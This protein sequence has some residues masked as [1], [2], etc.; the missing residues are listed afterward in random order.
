VSRAT[1]AHVADFRAGVA[2][3]PRRAVNTH[4]QAVLARDAAAQAAQHPTAR[5]ARRPRIPPPERPASRATAARVAAFRAGAAS[6][7]R[8][9]VNTHSQAVLARDAAA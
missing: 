9:A 7:P 1:A 5:A 4:S 6:R 8:R 2:S 3:R